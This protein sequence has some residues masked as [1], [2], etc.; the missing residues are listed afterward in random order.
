MILWWNLGL[1]SF[2]GYFSSQHPKI[3]S[4]LRMGYTKLQILLLYLHV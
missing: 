4:N 1:W 2:G 3:I